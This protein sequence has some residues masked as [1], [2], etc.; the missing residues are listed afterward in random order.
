MSRRPVPPAPRGPL[1]LPL[2]RAYPH[3]LGRE[4]ASAAIA[5]AAATP[6]IPSVRAAAARDVAVMRLIAELGLVGYWLTG[7]RWHDVADGACRSIRLRGPDG[8]ECHLAASV[9]LLEALAAWRMR[10]GARIGRPVGAHEPVFPVLGHGMRD[11]D[12]ERPLVGVSVGYFQQIVRRRLLDAGIEPSRA[13]VRLLRGALAP[14]RC[15]A[16]GSGDPGAE[17]A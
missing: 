13:S 10:L 14:E 2:A 9:E 8:I 3:A 1:A 5:A 4:E 15:R 17:A 16:A 7:L 12:A 11:W 6:R